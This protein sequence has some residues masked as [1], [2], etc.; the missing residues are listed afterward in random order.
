[1][2]TTTEVAAVVGGVWRRESPHV[3]AAL[4]RRHGDLGE[5]KDDVAPMAHEP[6]TDLD[7]PLAQGRER[8]LRHLVRQRQRAQEVGQVVRER[9]ELQAARARPPYLIFLGSYRRRTGEPR[10]ALVFQRPAP[11]PFTR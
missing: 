8:P 11:S 6:R 10:G 9:K 7:Q 4:L 2:A 3:L 1:M 5:L